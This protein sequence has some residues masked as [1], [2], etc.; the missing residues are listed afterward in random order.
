MEIGKRRKKKKTHRGRAR[1]WG[2]P[3]QQNHRERK[4]HSGCVKVGKKSDSEKGTSFL[5]R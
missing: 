1:G 2:V 3:I 5:E 4:V